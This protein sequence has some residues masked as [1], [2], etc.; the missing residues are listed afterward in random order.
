MKEVNKFK[1]YVGC[2]KSVKRFSAGGCQEISGVK[3]HRNVFFRIMKER[4]LM[5]ERMSVKNKVAQGIVRG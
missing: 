3:S 4:F 5:N 1:V 2:K